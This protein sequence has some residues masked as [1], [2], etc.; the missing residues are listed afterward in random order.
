[1]NE[2]KNLKSIKIINEI[3]KK[4]ESMRAFARLIQEQCS[5]V[6]R[7]CSGKSKIKV[8]AVIEICRLY[9]KLMPHELNHIV[10]PKDLTFSFTKRGKKLCK[11]RK[12]IPL[13]VIP[14]AMKPITQ[15]QE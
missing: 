11:R 12:S 15:V 5:D 8:R 2:E 1:M 14:S 7:W 13:A 10:F 4:H 6:S 3:V 9:P